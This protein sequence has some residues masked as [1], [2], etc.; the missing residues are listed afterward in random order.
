M[1]F[2]LCFF[3]IYFKCLF[4]LLLH[5]HPW[6]SWSLGNNYI[7]H[8]VPCRG[9]FLENLLKQGA[10]VIWVG[11]GGW[12]FMPFHAVDNEKPGSCFQKMGDGA[13]KMVLCQELS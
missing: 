12:F 3:L 6:K 11:G 9:P 13:A 7:M 8:Q 2:T 1:P 10:S 5:S 4:W